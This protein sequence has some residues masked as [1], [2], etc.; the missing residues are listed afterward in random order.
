MQNLKKNTDT[1]IWNSDYIRKNFALADVITVDDFFNLNEPDKFDDLTL[2]KEITSGGGKNLYCKKFIRIKKS[3]FLLKVAKGKFYSKLIYESVV[4]KYLPALYITPPEI[5]AYYANESERICIILFKYPPGFHLLKD[6][7]EM[8]LTPPILADFEVRKRNVMKKISKALHKMHY[9]EFYYPYLF[10]ENILVKH[11]SDEISII[12][13]EDFRPLNK[14]PWSY[15][16]EIVSW[17]IKKKEWSTLR[18]SLASNMYTKKYMKS[19]LK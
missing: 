3:R 12:D 8:R 7:I 1:V 11:K 19:L 17:F 18:K 2:K 6:V 16:I 15:R 14:C 13:L 5:E 4:L 9:S 10:A